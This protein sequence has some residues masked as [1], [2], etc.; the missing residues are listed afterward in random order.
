M[1]KGTVDV[2]GDKMTALFDSGIRIGF[3]CGQGTVLRG[4]SSSCWST[5]DLRTE[6]SGATRG[7]TGSQGS[8][9]RLVAEHRPIGDSEYERLRPKSDLQGERWKG[10]ESDDVESESAPERPG[11]DVEMLGVDH[12]WKVAMVGAPTGLHMNTVNVK[13]SSW[14]QYSKILNFDVFK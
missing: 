11:T 6:H 12:M 13:Q 8:F 1:L 7:Q 14:H 3:G 5:G 9:D 4:R 2:V 10:R